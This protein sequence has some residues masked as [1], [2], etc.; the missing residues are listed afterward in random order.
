MY[1]KIIKPFFDFSA[2]LVLFIIAFPVMLVVALLVRLDSRG[3]VLF[4]Q[5]R[6]GMNYRVFR[7]YKFRTMTHVKERQARQIFDGDPEVTRIG[8]YLRRL[9][10]DELP[11]LWNVLNGDM[12]F[13]GP[14]P[15]LPNLQERFN[16]DGK[17]RLMV[18]PGLTGLAQVNGSIYLT[19]PER[20]VYDR[21]YV[22][23]QSFLMDMG[24]MLKTVIVVLFGEKIFYK[25]TPKEA[26]PDASK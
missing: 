6:L 21:K 18:K 14:R 2:G 17:M 15:S 7:V 11:Q 10:L 12:S 9:K 19:W 26:S 25:N 13:V 8:V 22:E 1:R 4:M 3:P 23:Q 16:E 20:W 5:E 24:I